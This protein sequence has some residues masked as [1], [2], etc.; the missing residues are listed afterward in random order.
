[1]ANLKPITSQN[2]V[3]TISGAAG[4]SGTHLFTKATAP[5]FSRTGA[6][7]NDGQTGQELMVF[8]FSQRQ[9]LSIAKPYDPVADKAL[10]TWAQSI[11]EKPPANAEFTLTI[12]PVQSDIAGTPIPSAQA[13][14]FTGCQLVSVRMPDV[15]RQGTSTAMIE[16]EVYYVA[17]TLQ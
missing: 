16:M 17:S 15:D 1:M 9:N 13:R 2:F 6:S 7:Y 8:G 14:V 3:V 10:E 12:Q 11:M 4:L 5:R